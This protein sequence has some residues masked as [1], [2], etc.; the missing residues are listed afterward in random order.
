MKESV[1]II[2][3]FI[4]AFVIVA[5]AGCMKVSGRESRKEENAKNN[6]NG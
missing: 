3:V 2:I 6:Q 1:L 4:A 5:V